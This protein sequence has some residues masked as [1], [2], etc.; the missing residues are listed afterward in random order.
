M[1]KFR[2]WVVEDRNHTHIQ[3]AL[4]QAVGENGKYALYRV[5]PNPMDPIDT[6]A[7]ATLPR[8]LP[9][10]ALVDVNF[11]A[12]SATGPIVEVDAESRG[13]VVAAELKHYAHHFGKKDFTY[14][15]YTGNKDVMDQF[16]WLYNN[17]YGHE[18]LL[19]ISEKAG[20]VDG[21]QFIPWIQKQCHRLVKIRLREADI[22]LSSLSSHVDELKLSIQSLWSEE[23]KPYLDDFRQSI[24]PLVDSFIAAYYQS[25]KQSPQ[26]GSKVTPEYLPVQK[27]QMAQTAGAVTYALSLA[28]GKTVQRLAAPLNDR[29]KEFTGKYRAMVASTRDLVLEMAD[30]FKSEEIF[31]EL[32][33][34]LFPFE[35]WEIGD[36][37][38]PETIGRALRTIL[39]LIGES[40]DHNY[41]LA[42]A[43]KY[44]KIPGKHVVLPT[45]VFASAC[46]TWDPTK[47]WFDF[48]IPDIDD[49]DTQ[50]LLLRE[51]VG[52]VEIREKDRPILRLP[53]ESLKRIFN[54]G[55]RIS[56]G[57]SRHTLVE[58]AAGDKTEH[59]TGVPADY[60]K[61]K[62]SGIQVRHS[63]ETF[64]SRPEVL[65]DW[66]H[67]F[68]TDDTPNSG[69]FDRIMA[70]AKVKAVRNAEVH[71]D[72]E[73]KRVRITIEFEVEK[74]FGAIYLQKPGGGLTTALKEFL[75]WGQ[76]EVHTNDEFACYNTPWPGGTPKSYKGQ[77]DNPQLKLVWS[78][79]HYLET[80]A[81][82]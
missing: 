69:I 76:V 48:P 41:T 16:Q 79:P 4:E 32:I 1:D 34:P 44:F 33:G 80:R 77:T 45:T 31:E 13:F 75:G 27:L 3:L 55:E 46:H 73:A 36:S 38:D 30:K 74:Y 42:R 18:P 82:L 24:R 40:I 49:L 65:T 78:I 63:P 64:K 39:D 25:Q 23:W 72:D 71:Y 26:K 58:F 19:P 37:S 67:F 22:D 43:F 53:P 15:I 35:A 2:I 17:P 61:R 81:A 57:L 6:C 56:G 66:R 52:K 29:L 5:F 50:E 14:R 60:L 68:G 20:M 51:E 11:D 10:I 12:V 59:W 47:W 54:D 70:E 62:F 8:E 21:F 28:Q 9:D 7:R